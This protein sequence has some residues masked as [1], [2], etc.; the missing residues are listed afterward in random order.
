MT[1][2][3][4]GPLVDLP[5]P[6]G[7]VVSLV[8]SITEAIALT[9]PEKLVGCTQWCIRP[10]DI[11][12][13]AGHQVAR[14]RGT[15]NPDRAAIAELHPDLVV[16]NREENRQHD[17]DLLREAG[18]AVWVTSIDGVDQAVTSL[19][20]LFTETLGVAE[21]DWLAQAR[22]DW[23]A[24]VPEPELTAVVA[25]WRD[26]W[27]CAGATTYIEDS[28]A[29]CGVRLAA[30]PDDGT[31]Y[32]HVDLETLQGLGVDRI[33]LPDEPYHFT[34]EDGPEAFPGLDVRLVDGQK[35]AW[36]G[37]TMVGARQYL[38]DAVR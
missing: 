19:D 23:S 2:D 13:R 20:R 18:I 14:V 5:D 7:R 12:E 8:P 4:C 15:K 34:A 21:P 33:V 1:A 26:P 27:M 30:L 17:V 31:R 3:D 29:H 16:T 10:T 6:A 9:C 37:P 11:D 35:L 38:E 32:P 25:V 24:P 28:L 22:R 36:Y